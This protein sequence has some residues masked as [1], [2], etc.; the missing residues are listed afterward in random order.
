MKFKTSFQL[1]VICF[2]TYGLILPAYADGKRPKLVLQITVDQLRGDLPMRFKERLGKGGFRYLLERGTHYNN[3]HYQHANTETAPGHATLVTGADPSA[4]GIITNDWIDRETGQFV[5]NTEDERHHIIGGKPKPHEGVSPR[6]L[7]ASTIGDELVINNGGRSRVFSVSVKD[8]GAILPGGHAGKAFWFSKDSGRFVTSTY[9]YDDYPRWV[10]DWNNAKPTDHYKG[11]YW[12]L[13]HDRSTYIAG[14]MDDRP[15]EA[16]FAELGRTFPH[17]LG[18]GSSKYFNT[19]VSLTPFGD[20]LTLDFAKTLIE[21]EKVGQGEATDYMAIS[22]SSTDYVGHLFGPS[23][24]ETEDNILRLDQVLSKL[25]RYVDKT[26]GLDN[27]LIVLSADHGGPEA[28]EYIAEYGMETGRFLLD[29]FKEGSP[30][31][32]ALKKRFGRDDLVA[33]HS[34]PYLYLNLDA[35]E[36]AK[37]DIEEV[38]RFV[39]LEI[40][41]VD[42]IAYAMTRSDLLAGRI[43]ESP[44]QNQMRRNFHPVRSGDIYMVSEHYWFL[45]STEEAKQMGIEK[46]AAIHGSPWKYDTYVPVFFA[47]NGV[48]AQTISR[49]VGPQDIAATIAAYLEIK[50]PS[51]SIGVPLLEVLE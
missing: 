4:H 40:M 44:I 29:W 10:E 30:L 1:L 18:D 20:E 11:K 22:F 2:F 6:N 35:I 38:E 43:T 39:A 46:I 24:L 36:D 47:G 17:F 8:R 16:A 48:S 34:H 7:L 45:H 15:F 19:V 26:I 42:G 13:L 41:K 49:P 51:G 25:F 14:D 28:P 27:T 5:Y 21:N 32:D 37:L 12:D 3:A 9:Y 31:L 23:S 50:P 33:A